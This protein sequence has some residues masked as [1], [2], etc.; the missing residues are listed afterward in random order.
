MIRTRFCPSPTGY[1]HIGG[2]RTALYNWLFARQNGGQF[3]LR[4]D[5]TDDRRNDTT[6]L[7]V[8]LQGLEWLGLDWDEGPV[9]GGPYG[10]YY[11]SERSARYKE[12]ADGLVAADQ[13]YID[14]GAVRLRMGHGVLALHDMARGDVSWVRDSIADPVIVRSDGKALYNLATAVDDHDMRITHVIRAEEHLSNTPVQLRIFE[15]MGWAGPAIRPPVF[16][17]RPVRA[18]RRPGRKNCRSGTCS[19]S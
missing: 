16:R 11:Q 6:M 8:I 14:G 9:F 1:L 10:P 4:I 17:L 12:V 19:G 15:A 13:A 3:V 2:V 18:R 7:D 5:D